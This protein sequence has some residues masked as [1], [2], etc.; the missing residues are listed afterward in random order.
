MSASNDPLSIRSAGVLLHPTSLPGAFGIGDLGPA[1]Y[2]WIDTLD[3][4]KI[5][6]WQILPLG[7][8]GFGNSPYQAYSAFAG[9]PVLVSPLGLRDDG[10]VDEGDFAGS[11]P[12]GP[13]VDYDKVIPFKNKLLAKAWENFQK[14]RGKHLTGGFDEFRKREAV[15]LDDY[16]LFMAIKDARGGAGWL[17]WPKE[18]R[19][20]EPKALE[21]AKRESEASVGL[22]AFRQ[23]LFYRQ[24][25]WLRDYAQKRNIRIIGDLP[26]FVSGDSSDVWANPQFFKLNAERQPTVVAG[27][28][29]DYFNA[30]GQLWGNPL[31]DWDAMAKSGYAWW[32]ARLKASFELV[33]V[34]RL[35]H[36]RGFE[37]YWEVPANSPTAKTG[38]WVKAPGADFLKK[39]G[40]TFRGL[41][42][43]AEDLGLIT[44][45]V[46]A[47]RKQFD[48]PGM[49]VL[50]FAF[51]GE[52][53]HMYLPHSY[54]HRTVVYTG[55][56]DNDTT[57]GWY[58]AAPSHEK[59]F[60]RR[61]LGRG[62]EDISWDLIRLAWESV[63][64]VAVVPLQDVL[65]LGS[66][67][68]MN[69]PGKALGN[70][71]WRCEPHQ[72]HPGTLDRLA[73]LTWLYDRQRK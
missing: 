69:F 31:Y 26:I 40:E 1:A 58:S 44:P 49:K 56:H 21:T 19:L 35:D 16:A 66:E 20:R 9:N 41:P 13:K 38:K 10:L 11:F 51:G 72:L 43:I 39:V 4:A 27:V 67:S 17:E 70:W 47:L 45:E 33:D 32:I 34:V 71:A 37:S 18:L 61:Y 15:W 73:E 25:G 63:A 2:A 42:I 12:S 22:H 50:H 65:N 53:H 54:E 24:W 23:F 52:P 68:R 57:R 62:G 55:T 46:D 5:T 8:T 29:P 60:V 7:P 3:R 28:P 64:N 30:D 48:L 6:W 36:F 59:D 14:G